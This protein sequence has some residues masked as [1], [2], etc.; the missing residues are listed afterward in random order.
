MRS[1]IDGH[2]VLSR[3]LAVKNHYPAIDIL[4][5]LSRVMGDVTLPDHQV[6][7]GKL[8]E[9]LAV[10]AEAEDLINIGAYVK[11]SSAK[12]DAAIEMNDAV[13]TYLRQSV[14]ESITFDDS[15]QELHNLFR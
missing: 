3:D 4:Q 8:R 7:A 5:S 13:S 14:D 15:V 11:G 10:Y 12:I 6:L 2:I 1:I 9:T